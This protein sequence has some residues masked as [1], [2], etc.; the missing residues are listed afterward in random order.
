MISVLPLGA[1]AETV[2]HTGLADA[3]AYVEKHPL[4]TSLSETLAQNRVVFVGEMHDR[5]DHHL[6]QLAVLQA[7]HQKNPN[8]AIG[9]EWFQQ[10]FQGG[11]Q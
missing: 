9:V 2:T 1:A 11:D 4:A 5:Y 7:L 3:L 10:P 8:I 6:N